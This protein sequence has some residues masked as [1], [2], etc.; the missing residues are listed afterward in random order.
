MG[1]C[2]TFVKG[3]SD[4]MMATL[5]GKEYMVHLR[6]GAV[7]RKGVG[8]IVA[9]NLEEKISNIENI[10]ETIMFF[11]VEGKKD[12]MIAQVIFSNI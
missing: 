8:A 5:S 9:K 11:F 7:E 12:I 1:I 3:N 2:E 4:N 10:D 6:R